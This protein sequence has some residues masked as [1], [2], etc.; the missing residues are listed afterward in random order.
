MNIYKSLLYLSF[1][2]ALVCAQNPHQPGQ[3]AASYVPLSASEKAQYRLLE[4][5]QPQ[6]LAGVA[7]AAAAEQ[8]AH[9]PVEWRQGVEGYAKRYAST[10]GGV[11]VRES[12]NIGFENLLK[13]D[14]RYFPLDGPSKKARL[15]NALKQTFVARTDSGSPTFAYARIASALASGQISRAWL[16]HSE[17]SLADGFQNGGIGI[18]AD[19]FVN[20]LYEFVPRSRPK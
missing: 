13:E 15:W 12:L 1:A 8:L 14:P 5:V 10:Y 9:A 18:G 11:V 19:A 7:M 2:V 20:M 4:L 16:P 17:N 6:V 3:L